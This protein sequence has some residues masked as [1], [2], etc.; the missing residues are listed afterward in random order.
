MSFVPNPAVMT[1]LKIGMA[2]GL[3]SA[4][5]VLGK[6]LREYLSKPGTGR[7]YKIRKGGRLPRGTLKG[8]GRVGLLKKIEKARKRKYKNLRTAGIHVASSPGKPP[9]ANTGV[10]RESLTISGNGTRLEKGKRYG[11][12]VEM[13]VPNSV[14]FIFGTTVKYAPWLEY[15]A[16]RV[17]A[18]PYLRPV[19]KAVEKR[20]V[21]AFA[22]GLKEAFRNA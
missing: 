1:Q 22:F 20:M 12:L 7:R 19:M 18:R 16:G 6:R 21:Q 10:L 3:I 17:K 4:Q 11:Y 8:L 2:V 14:G 13:K 5:M 15:G 9:A